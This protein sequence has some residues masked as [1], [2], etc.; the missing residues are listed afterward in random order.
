MNFNWFH[1]VIGLSKPEMCTNAENAIIPSAKR[2]RNRLGPLLD[3]LIIIHSHDH[4]GDALLGVVQVVSGL[5][6]L[7]V[8]LALL[9]DVRERVRRDPR[10][11]FELRVEKKVAIQCSLVWTVAGEDV[12]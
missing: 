3:P 6:A 2:T 8:D 10:P 9:C 4:S 5:E 1:Y 7:R 11:G 12:M